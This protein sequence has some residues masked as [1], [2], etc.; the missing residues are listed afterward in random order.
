MATY[1]KILAGKIPWTEEPGVGEL[2]GGTPWDC[3]ESDMSEATEHTH[4]HTHTHTLG[5]LHGIAKS[6]P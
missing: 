3:K 1:S 4:T 5:G 6:W 2:G